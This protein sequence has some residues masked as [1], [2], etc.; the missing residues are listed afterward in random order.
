M[1]ELPL[2]ALSSRTQS[3]IVILERIDNLGG[4]FGPSYVGLMKDLTGGYAGGLYGLASRLGLAVA[5]M[6]CVA[7]PA[8][9]D[10][11]LY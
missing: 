6:L 8:N 1:A 4:F 9:A 11:Y 5:A 10:V 3:Q 7:A 2:R